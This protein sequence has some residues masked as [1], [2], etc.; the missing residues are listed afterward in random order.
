MK[1]L[2]LVQLIKDRKEYAEK[3]VHK[4]DIGILMMGERNGY[5][6]VFFD[7]DEYQVDGITLI[8][9]VEVAV[10]P[11]DLKVLND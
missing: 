1:E 11:D 8:S 6:L 4:G 10:R 3:G 2:D 9:D 7:G 5:V